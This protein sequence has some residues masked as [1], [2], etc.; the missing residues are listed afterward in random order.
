MQSGAADDEICRV[1]RDG[2]LTSRARLAVEL[3][4]GAFRVS[5]GER[6]LT[7]YAV[8]DLADVET[9][10]DFIIRLDELLTWD[11]P[12]DDLEIS[13]EDLQ[14][15]AAGISAECDRRGLSVAFE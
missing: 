8:K 10:T 13:V 14:R 9:P 2:S 11:P 7:I 1:Y 15:I 12:H 4:E 5:S 3:T 6:R